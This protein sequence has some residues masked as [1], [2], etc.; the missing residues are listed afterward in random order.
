M[1][2]GKIDNR[3]KYTKMV[4]R[5]SL[6][7]L[8][9]TKPINKIT[10]TEICSL[11][12][13]NRGTFYKHYLDV[14]D[15]IEQIESELYNQIQ[16]TIEEFIKSEKKDIYD[17]TLKLFETLK[18]NKKFFKIIFSESGNKNIVKKLYFTMY[19]NYMENW[20]NTS[21]NIDEKT[22]DYIFTFTANGSIS[23]IQRWLEK[24]LEESPEEIAILINKISEFGFSAFIK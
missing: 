13:I 3:I 6:L 20:K 2:K 10:V 12:D 24:D 7:E 18:E 23:T 8:L 21:N 22:L 19:N 16:S 17:L 4:I 15:L 14:F 5:N 9:N 11:A 1:K